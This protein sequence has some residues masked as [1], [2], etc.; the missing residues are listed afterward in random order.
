MEGEFLIQQVPGSGVNITEWYSV[1]Q[2]VGSVQQLKNA[3]SARLVC[4]V[5]I[6]TGTCNS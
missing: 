6:C 5:F 4:A 3:H 2:T 1:Y